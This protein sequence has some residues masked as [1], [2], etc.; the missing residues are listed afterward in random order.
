MSLSDYIFG[1]ILDDI[2]DNARGG[3][4]ISRNRRAEESYIRKFGA[5]LVRDGY[6]GNKGWLNEEFFRMNPGYMDWYPNYIRM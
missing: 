1:K 5:E 3:G 6:I 2:W 4:R